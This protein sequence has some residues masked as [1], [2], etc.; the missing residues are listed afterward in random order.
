MADKITIQ[1]QGFAELADTLKNFGERVAKNGLRSAT[2][3][4]A[5]KVKESIQQ[6]A[7]VDTGLLRASI[8]TFRRRTP[9][10]VAQYSVGLRKLKNPKVSHFARNAATGKTHAIAGPEFYGRIVERGRKTEFGSSKNGARPFMR[11][12]FAQ[13]SGDAIEAIRDG[14]AKAVERAVKKGG[15]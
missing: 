12:G 14:L 15:G 6:K 13:A 3:A 2:Y 11:P 5:K 9:D 4:G 10:N 7:P 1:L 8:S